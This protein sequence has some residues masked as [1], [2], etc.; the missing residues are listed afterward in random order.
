MSNVFSVRQLIVK[1]KE[2]VTL[3]HQELEKIANFF[4]RSTAGGWINTAASM[5]KGIPPLRSTD[6]P[7]EVQQALKSGCEVGELL[8]GRKQSE[9]ILPTLSLLK[10]IEADHS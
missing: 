6:Q 7:E 4:G 1:F 3:P 9:W 10:E 8:L 5:S 2:L